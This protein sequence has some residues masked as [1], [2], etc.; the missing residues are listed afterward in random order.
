MQNVREHRET[1]INTLSPNYNDHEKSP[2]T[3][4]E[5]KSKLSEVDE[6]KMNYIKMLSKLDGE[7]RAIANLLKTKAVFDTAIT[8]KDT[9]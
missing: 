7:N 5:K 9:K 1:L 6:K 4:K 2:A 8:E 3:E